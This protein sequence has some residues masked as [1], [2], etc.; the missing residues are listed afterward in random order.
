[1]S[2]LNLKLWI[3]T[4]V[5][6]LGATPKVDTTGIAGD[7][8]NSKPLQTR[9]GDGNP[10]TLQRNEE[11]VSDQLSLLLFVCFYLKKESLKTP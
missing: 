4:D 11:E 8:E 9:Q 6:L 10:V 2:H 1:M 7:V 5:V 3:I